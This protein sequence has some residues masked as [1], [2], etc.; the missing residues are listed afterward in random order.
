MNKFKV[1][2]KKENSFRDG[3]TLVVNA[4]TSIEAI[5]NVMVTEKC[6]LRDVKRV[7][8]SKSFV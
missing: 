8:N 4:D 5:K 7:S 3:K 1:V 2:L 6:L